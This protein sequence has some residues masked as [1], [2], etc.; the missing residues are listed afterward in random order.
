MQTVKLS[1][2]DKNGRHIQVI[3]PDHFGEVFQLQLSERR[4]SPEYEAMAQ[5]ADG[6]LLFVHPGKL[7]LGPRL[8]IANILAITIKEANDT[9]SAEGNN[10]DKPK[11]WTY[12]DMPTQVGYVELLQFLL[13]R[14]GSDKGLN[15]VVIIS[16][17]DLIPQGNPDEVLRTYLPLLHQFLESNNDI[18]NYSVVGVSAQGGDLKRDHTKLVETMSASDRIQVEGLNCPPHDITAPISWLL[19]QQG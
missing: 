4:W 3:I 19:D 14:R 12:D 11:P 13:E 15:T 7:N 6:I 8:D 9:S 10:D 5:S 17:W 1:L 18:I 16:A 2:N